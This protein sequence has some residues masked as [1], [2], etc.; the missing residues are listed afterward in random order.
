MSNI[1]LITLPTHGARTLGV[2]INVVNMLLNINVIVQYLGFIPWVDWFNLVRIF[3]N[4][5]LNNDFSILI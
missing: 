2:A 1:V 4:V 3:K 5:I